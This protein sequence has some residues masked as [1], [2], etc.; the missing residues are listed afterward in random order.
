MS[1]NNTLFLEVCNLSLQGL[2]ERLS[3]VVKS[4]DMTQITGANGSGKTSL[5][6]TLCG[7]CAPDEGE[8]LWNRQNILRAGE[9]YYADITYVGHQDGIRSE[10]TPLENLQFAAALSEGEMALSPQES[11]KKFNLIDEHRRCGQLSTGQRRRVA[12]AK[13]L[14]LRARLW[15]L[16]EPLTALDDAGQRLLGGLVEAH[17]SAGGAAVIATHQAPMWQISHHHIIHLS[18][19]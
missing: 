15:F 19:R 7:L 16:D 18:R 11:L 6:K 3:F 4:G 5:I 2:W 17:L 9:D 1:V 12:L 8:V 14:L 13:L 10:L